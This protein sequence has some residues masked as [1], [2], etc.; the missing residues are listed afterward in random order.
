MEL[1]NLRKGPQDPALFAVPQNMMKLPGG[2]LAPL[3]GV[4]KKG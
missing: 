4:G 2:A 1:S 3:L